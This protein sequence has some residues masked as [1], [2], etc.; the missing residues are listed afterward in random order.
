MLTPPPQ[1]ASM[2]DNIRFLIQFAVESQKQYVETRSLLTDNQ[3]R[4]KKTEDQ[5]V[6][7]TAE[8]K[9]LKETVNSREQ[10]SKTLCVRIL[11]LSLS[12]DEMTGPDPAAATAKQAY[13]RIIKPILISSKAK[14]KIA[15]VPNIS[16]VIT[17]AFRTAKPSLHRSSPPPPII[18]HLSSP[19]LKTVIFSNKKDALPTPSDTEK[20]AGTKRFILC[21]DLTADS[22]A[23][24]KKLRE[25]ERVA[26]AWSVDG[27]MKFIKVNDS[28]NTIMKVRSIYDPIDNIFK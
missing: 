16:N 10:Q 13:D 4:I 11:G 7:L 15:S 2:E 28:S 21:E 22:F 27:Q 1:D 23:F 5:V 18:L 19:S 24:L 26:R 14:G 8:V 12:E 17:K 3:T 20:A 6:A 25:D 9:K